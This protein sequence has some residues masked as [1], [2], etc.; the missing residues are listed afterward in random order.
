M[1]FVP[2]EHGWKEWCDAEEFRD[3]NKENSFTFTL[4]DDANI[5]HIDSVSDLQSLPKVKDKFDL[6]FSSWYLLDFE[7]LAEIWRAEFEK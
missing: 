2:E 7:K 3:C 4:A 1:W 5:L 6:N